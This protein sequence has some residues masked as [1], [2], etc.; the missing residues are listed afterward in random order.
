MTDSRALLVEYAENG[1]ESAFQELVTRYIDLV[2]STALRRVGGDAHLAQDVAQTVFLHLVRKARSLPQNVMLG[3]W[4][5]QATG[6][7]AAT[8]MRTERRR[9]VRERQAVQMNTLQNDSTG[10]LDH[11][12]LSST[13][14]SANSRRRTA[15]P[16]CCAFSRSAISG[17]WARRWAAAR[18]RPGCAST[19]PWRSWRSY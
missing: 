16:S 7:V 12:A 10:T 3:G 2:Y 19:A 15:R 18:T 5:H 14:P 1:A 8:V 4:L 6:N 9:Q 11:V 17:R 13:R